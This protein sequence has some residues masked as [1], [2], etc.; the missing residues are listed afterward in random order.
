[1]A[2]LSDKAANVTNKTI[3][4]FYRESLPVH[5]ELK[6][7]QE[8]VSSVNG[9]LRNIYKR[10]KESGVSEKAIAR[11][12]KE[13][14]L[15]PEEVTKDLHDYIRA[16]AIIS[17]MPQEQVDMFAELLSS[18]VEAETAELIA[19]DKVYDDGYLAGSEGGN[20]DRNPHAPGSEQYDAWD[21]AWIKGQEKIVASLT[22]KKRGRPPKP[23]EG[24]LDPQAEVVE[25]AEAA[26]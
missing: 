22:P 13:R 11:L 7:A 1:M 24:K 4:D 23:K 9:R 25:K 5:R 20:R 10:A 19:L 12:L 15:D 8:L 18:S 26:E 17:P 16:R 21:R 6:A 2:N 14:L 3:A